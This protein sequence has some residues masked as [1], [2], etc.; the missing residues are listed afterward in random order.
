[1]CSLQARY[2]LVSR[3]PAINRENGA[4]GSGSRIHPKA[5]A[6]APADDYYISVYKTKVC[7]FE[8]ASLNGLLAGPGLA[9]AMLVCL[10]RS[11]TDSTMAD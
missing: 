8:D 6:N 9:N 5:L 7:A 1:M 4:G 11:R 10:G 3:Q 2:V